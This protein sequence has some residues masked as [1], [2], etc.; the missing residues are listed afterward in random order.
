MIMLIQAVN[1]SPRQT[2]PVIQLTVATCSL[3]VSTAPV[4]MS[5]LLR[6]DRVMLAVRSRML[7]LFIYCVC[8]LA[9]GFVVVVVFAFD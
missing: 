7:S 2:T 8:L 6:R 1:P 4:T 5:A 3:V 9:F